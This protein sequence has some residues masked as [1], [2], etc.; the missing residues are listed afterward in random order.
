MDFRSV[1]EH[2]VFFMVE[3]ITLCNDPA[4]STENY[5]N[6]T[7]D[8]RSTVE[9]AEDAYRLEMFEMP[10]NVEDAYSLGMFEMRSNVKDAYSLG[11]FEMPSNLE[12]AYNPNEGFNSKI[13]ANSDENITYSTDDAECVVDES[14]VYYDNFT[15]STEDADGVV[16]ES[17]VYYENLTYSTEDADYV[18]DESTVYYENLTYST[19][20]VVFRREINDTE[21]DDIIRWRS[22]ADWR[23]YFDSKVVTVNASQKGTRLWAGDVFSDFC[24][25]DSCVPFFHLWK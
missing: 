20:D 24:V 1:V 19:E 3:S 11:M 4:N 23:A 5:A 15:Y 12:D 17:T 6:G 8:F 22:D 14:T 21:S 16:D 25:G 18:V 13:S 2:A 7:I 9:H 10:S